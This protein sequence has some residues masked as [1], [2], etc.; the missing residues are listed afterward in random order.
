MTKANKHKTKVQRIAKR[1]E[2]RAIRRCSLQAFTLLELLLVIAIISVL[3]GIIIFA[4]KPA[5]RINSANNSKAVAHVKDLEKALKT[6]T[7]DNEGNV[8]AGLST[9]SQSGIYDICKY[10]ETTGCVNLDSLIASRHLGN[11]PV[12]T[13]NVTTFTTG[14][15]VDYNTTTKNLSVYAKETYDQKIKYCPPGDTCMG[16]VAEWLFDEGIGLTAVDTS[17]NGN[18]GTLNAASWGIGKIGKATSFNG[19]SDRVTLPNSASIKGSSQVTFTGWVRPT[20][21]IAQLIYFE[22]TGTS[23]YSRFAISLDS[24]G[25]V[26]LVV[27]DSAQDPVGSVLAISSINPITLNT[28]S[29]ITA[30]Y[31]SINDSHKIYINGQLDKTDATAKGSFANTT[32]SEIRIGDAN[33]EKFSGLIDQVRIF[34]YARTP[35]Q[36]AWEYNQGLPI[37]QWKFDETSGTI[38][39]DSSGSGNDGT[40]VGG[41]VWTAG[42]YGNALSFDN[43]DDYIFKNNFSMFP[44]TNISTSV[45]VKTNDSNNGIVSYASTSADNDW[46]IFNAANLEL[47]R[48][49]WLITGVSANDNNWT[50]LAVTRNGSTG[51]TKLYR[52]GLLAS[53]GVISAGTFITNNGALVI[54]QEQDAVGGAFDVNQAYGG[55]IDDVR[56][57]NYELTQSQIF[58]IMQGN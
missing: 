51:M 15:K 26:R 58:Q 11:I 6:Y 47:Y 21:Q 13:R 29:H 1:L 5:D 53:S 28:W 10:G 25:Y 16:P 52:N 12:D 57:Y 41:P 9:I 43:V 31:D 20:L 19:S 32:P 38:A 46:L 39:S 17:G 7:L 2:L 33:T 54:G 50:H 36:V 24:S 27:R 42:K 55:L 30:I 44:T 14:Y 22:S 49:S 34:N 23:N 40:L 18:N 45:W 48:S 37:L 8:P 3:A 35:A 4:L 56:I